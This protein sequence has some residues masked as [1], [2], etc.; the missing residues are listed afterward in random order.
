MHAC[1]STPMGRIRSSPAACCP[2]M[3]VPTGSARGG[4]GGGVAHRAPHPITRDKLPRNAMLSVLCC[5]PIEVLRSVAGAA[6]VAAHV[7]LA[8]CARHCC[9]TPVCREQILGRD[10]RPELLYA[11]G[12][13]PIVCVDVA[14]SSEILP[15]RVARSA[16][17][18]TGQPVTMVFEEPEATVVIGTASVPFSTER[19]ILNRSQAMRLGS[20]LFVS[21][22]LTEAP[23][24]VPADQLSLFGDFGHRCDR[25]AGE[26]R[27]AMPTQD[28]S[29]P[30]AYLILEAARLFRTPCSSR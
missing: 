20:Q 1:H 9:I 2:V 29:F 16:R 13:G 14:V 4:S 3:S 10:E 15:Y 6:R 22:H 21:F 17:F 5:H 18:P 25:S 30:S 11:P 28:V 19:N 27:A 23:A 24:P 7:Q 26:M 8:L 12:T